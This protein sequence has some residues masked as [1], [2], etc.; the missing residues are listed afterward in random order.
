MVAEQTTKLYTQTVKSDNG[1]RFGLGKVAIFTILEYVKNPVY[2]RSYIN[3]D[4]QIMIAHGY[5]SFYEFEPDVIVKKFQ[6]HN[7]E[8]NQETEEATITYSV[9][10]N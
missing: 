7:I 1:L 9:I 4:N 8:F 10:D 5:I 3:D 2:I 6:I